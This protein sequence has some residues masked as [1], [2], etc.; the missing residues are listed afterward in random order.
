MPSVR[1]FFKQFV[2]MS[3]MPW[4]FEKDVYRH[5]VFAQILRGVHSEMSALGE[6][7]V[8]FLQSAHTITKKLATRLEL[9][10]NYEENVWR[11]GCFGK[12]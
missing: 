5:G 1:R 6:K 4:V 12:S 9:R 2:S 11:C 8:P 7:G 10:R 3:C